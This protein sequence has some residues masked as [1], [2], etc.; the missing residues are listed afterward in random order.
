M[1]IFLNDDEVNTIKTALEFH[2]EK[3]KDEDHNN[4]DIIG[5]W[6]QGAEKLKLLILDKQKQEKSK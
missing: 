2:I 4:S 5:Q 3:L 1:K 6:I